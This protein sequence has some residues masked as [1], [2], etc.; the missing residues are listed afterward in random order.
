MKKRLQ[1]RG[2]RK[3]FTLVEL[4][5]VIIIIGILAGGM[6][7]VAG[8]SRDSAEA[9]RIISDLR[10]VKS[11]ALMWMVENPMGYSDKDWTDFNDDP[12]PLNKYL[13]RALDKNTMR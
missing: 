2:A 8:S 7:L 10:T 9:A 1:R 4:L 13:D 3:G 6:M 5:I 11:A 12:S